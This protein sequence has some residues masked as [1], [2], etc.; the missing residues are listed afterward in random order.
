MLRSLDAAAPKRYEAAG[1]VR[2]LY[3]IRSPYL[4]V[5]GRCGCLVYAFPVAH[6]CA[7]PF[8]ANAGNSF[9]RVA[10]PAKFP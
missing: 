7:T 4:P 3:M 9:A 1:W 10:F 2:A 5:V 6:I 8:G